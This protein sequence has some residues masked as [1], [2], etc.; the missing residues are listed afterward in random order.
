MSS[1]R[2]P[3]QPKHSKRKKT[4]AQVA[5]STLSLSLFLELPLDLLGVVFSFLRKHVLF[6]AVAP[7][8]K[9]FYG[10]TKLSWHR[11]KKWFF[12]D[13][14]NAGYARRC[15][16]DLSPSFLIPSG[17]Y[18]VSQPANL[19]LLIKNVLSHCSSLQ[20]LGFL[21]RNQ[22]KLS[23]RGKREESK[24][25]HDCRRERKEKWKRESG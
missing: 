23:T 7:S 4:D 8:C 24:F 20:S 9:L 16:D 25:V 18:P 5:S 19:Q 11:R 1:S 21:K 2:L 15:T 6:F 3:S 13:P 10:A 12:G 22:L 14:E 17:L